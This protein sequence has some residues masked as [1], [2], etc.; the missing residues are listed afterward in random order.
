ML[1]R[2][3]VSLVLVALI[4]A[5]A[6]F[7]FKRLKSLKPETERMDSVLL[8]ILV[9]ATTVERDDHVERLR[10]YG[11]AK[12]L[13]RTE[14]VSLMDGRVTEV[15]THLEVGDE[16]HAKPTNGSTS[17]VALP[18]LAKLDDRD[19][20]DR[21]QRARLDAKATKLEIERLS[22]Q[23]TF[24]QER[25]ALAREE[26]ET[27]QREYDR[28][29]PLVPKTLTPSDLDRQRLQVTI[30]ER[31]IQTLEGTLE[32]NSRQAKVA[33]A[34]VEA[35]NKT[36]ELEERSLEWTRIRAPSEGVVLRRAVEPS[37]WV[38]RGD[39][40]FELVDLSRTEVPVT[41]SASRYDDVRPGTKLALF[42][43]T[44]TQKLWEGS[45]TRRS[46]GIDT[47]S[48]TF[49]AFVEIEGT[50]HQNVIPPGRHVRAEVVGRTDANVFVV[51]RQAFLDDKLF[52]AARA[53]PT[54]WTPQRAWLAGL[55]HTENTIYEVQVRDPVVRRWLPGVGL[56]SEGLQ[57]GEWL[58]LTNLESIGDGGGVRVTFDEQPPRP[59]D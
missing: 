41:L 10:G 53:K 47:A 35:A 19:I 21:A 25:L 40:L 31:R 51:P 3:V 59:G 23:R 52:V 44:T 18:V 29:K 15:A 30:Q 5:A 33:A 46:P 11:V 28:I 34:R 38:R 54:F 8:P 36:I 9:R 13:R 55:P 58:L 27:A 1:A 39:V 56:V 16:V 50:P 26:K 48:R 43:P 32:D 17:P 7:G 4:G 6:S 37:D 2:I 20:R 22:A 42:D 24:L 45:V 57:D 12:S 49:Q 14:A